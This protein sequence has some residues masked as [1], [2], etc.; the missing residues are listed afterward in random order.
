V[1]YP[2]LLVGSV[3]LRSATEVFEL[4]GEGLGD[5]L[6]RIPDGETGGRLGFIAWAGD[7]IS[8]AVGVEVDRE[9][10][11]PAWTSGKMFKVKERTTAAQIDFGPH[12]YADVALESYA[13]F[14]FL[15]EQGRIPAHLRFQVSLPTAMG[16]IFSHTSP[17]S[18]PTMWAAYEQHLL[19]DVEQIVRGIPP[20]DLA[21][22]WDVA[23]E[24]DRILEFPEVAAEFSMRSLVDSIAR[25][26]EPIPAEVELG[27]HLCYG[28]PGHKHIIEPKDMGLM[29]QLSNRLNRSIGRINWI[30]MPVPKERDDDAY[31]EP[32]RNLDVSSSTE[33]YLGLV[34]MTDG[35]DG[36]KRRLRT[37]KKFL[38]SFGVATECGW[39]RRSP[40]IIPDLIALHRSVAQLLASD[41]REEDPSLK[42]M[43]EKK[44]ESSIRSRSPTSSTG[45]SAAQAKQYQPEKYW[46]R[47]FAPSS[48]LAVITTVDRDGR[49]NA[50]AFGT[51]TRV[52]HNPVYIAFTTTVGNDTA[53]NVLATGEF[54]VNLP[55]FEPTILEKVMV[56]GLPFARGTNE[57]EKAGF[58]SRPARA[59]RP[60]LIVEC[61]RNFECRVEWTR[62]WGPRRLMVCGQVVA[63]AVDSD[64]V[65]AKGYVVWDRVKPAHYCGAPYGSA[66]VAAYEICVVDIPYD[67]I[68]R[69]Q[70][71]ERRS[72]M[73]EDES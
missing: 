71:E 44:I 11:G 19:K 35:A 72:A 55:P 66:F 32:L 28:D 31:F 18:R 3:P 73:F 8:R 37:A 62:E 34:H 53:D 54:T 10:V 33:I 67:G 59:V 47:L 2:V 39:G 41:F 56:V 60:P 57:L 40:E 29:V 9:A 42:K 25:L 36:A 14:K 43:E 61:P 15:R 17:A 46:D 26:S 20:S 27:I 65:D 52:L 51:C 1:R 22:Q 63:A 12:I 58:S 24:I 45:L 6:A 50:A 21:I 69:Q 70:F 38:K 68:E 5:L 30:H 7:Q 23:T 64:C 4:M 48:C 13:T 16:I 49:V